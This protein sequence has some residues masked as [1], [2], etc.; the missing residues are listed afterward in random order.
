MKLPRQAMARQPQIKECNMVSMR[1]VQ[2]SNGSHSSWLPEDTSE[3]RRYLQGA[4]TVAL[5]PTVAHL[6]RDPS[7]LRKEWK[8]AFYY[9]NPISGLPQDEEDKIRD[10]CAEKLIE[11][12]RSGKPVPSQRSYDEVRAFCQWMMPEVHEGYTGMLI[13]E[14]V[15]DKHDPREPRWKLDSKSGAVAPHVLIIGAGESGLLL[16]YRLK[17]AGVPFTII[18]KNPGVGGTW[19][20]ND[21]PGCRVDANSFF[22]SYAFARNIWEEYYSQAPD[23][24]KYFAR[25]AEETGLYE[26]IVL[27]AEVTA[28]VWDEQAAKWKVEYRQG[29]TIQLI[30]SEFVTSAVGQLN[31]PSLPNI[32]GRELFAGPAFHSA[33]WDHNVD[34]TGKRVAVIGI[35]A[36]AI[37]IIPQ[38][39]K[40]AERVT[41]L[42]RSM[43]WLVPTPLIHEHVSEGMKWALQNIPSYALWLRATLAL[44]GAY[45]MLDWVV[46]DPDYPPTERSVSALNDQVRAVITA[47][48][49]ERIA[50]RPD[51]RDLLIPS[52]PFAAKRITRDNGS[53]IETLK[54]D[55][56]VVNRT[57]I[58]EIEEGG[59]VFTDGSREDYDVIIYATGFHAS[60]FLMPMKVLGEDSRDL[61][62]VWDGDDARAYLGMTVPHFPNLFILYGPNTN[63]AVHGG[64]AIMWTEFSVKYVLDAVH[65][66]TLQGFRS[67]SVK[68]DV[69]ETYSDRIDE[70]GALRTW[71]FS[72]VSSWYKNSKGRSTQNFPFS[73]YELWWRTH[74]VDL[75][76][77]ELTY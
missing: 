12:V 73:S 13:E 50:D 7:V 64:S 23:L 8:P 31:R 35:G 14:L 56:V 19:F 24:R 6:T 59:I 49:E 68:Q 10:F 70:A 36:S 77:Y 9:G 60:R 32:K 2:D 71:G 38:V 62:A 28:C 4:D 75:S 42:C 34:L 55:N 11:F 76:D 17:Q 22:Y 69:F 72:D 41:V 18:E 37:Q 54:R 67:L 51:L 47:W 44:P 52:S 30:E 57:P 27:N 46:V 40:V 66:M 3:L 61:H 29:D 53:F 74:Q 25:I 45:G 39:A 1:S 58:Q 43:P 33:R 48:I 15:C 63:Q 65:Q 16:G 26:N 5:L 21:Y 20:E